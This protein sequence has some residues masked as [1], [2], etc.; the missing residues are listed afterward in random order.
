MTSQT[1]TLGIF[2]TCIA[3]MLWLA[4]A[5]LVLA[6]KQRNHW[7]KRFGLMIVVGAGALYWTLAAALRLA[8]ITNPVLMTDLSRIWY[9]LFACYSLGFGWLNW[10]PPGVKPD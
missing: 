10:R 3:V 6:G 5:L 7:L 2:A 9:A 1:V 4:L 8:N